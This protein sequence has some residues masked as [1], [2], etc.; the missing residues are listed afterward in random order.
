MSG[1]AGAASAGDCAKIMEPVAASASSD[2]TR[3]RVFIGQSFFSKRTTT[4]TP[5]HGA[6]SSTFTPPFTALPGA[7]R[8]SWARNHSTLNRPGEPVRSSRKRAVRFAATS[9]F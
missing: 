6:V 4:S 1:G 2:A 9:A 7:L 3:N 8:P 5:T